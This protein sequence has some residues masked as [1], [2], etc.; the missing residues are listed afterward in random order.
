MGIWSTKS[1]ARLQ[2]EEEGGRQELRRTLT[3]LNLVML[4]VGAIIGAGIFVV[5][6][7]AAAQHAGP[8]I[9]L[10]FVLAGVGCLFAGLCYAEFSAMIPVAGS[11]YTYGYAT[12]GEL[13][14]WLIGWDLMLEYLFA[15]SAVAVGWSGYFT[16]FLRDY[17]HVE[18]PRALTSAPFD[19]EPGGHLLHA[20]GAV[21][22]LP[23]ALLVGVITVMLVLGMRESARLNNVIVVVKITVVLLVIGFGAAH[24]DTANWT[25]FVPENTGT[26]GQF[27][28]SGV[29]SGAGVI[30]FAYIGF[31]A[32]STA[33][34]ETRNPQ[35]DLP[36]GILG[37]LVVCT[38]LYMA[39]ALVMTGLAP[40]ATLNV[41]EPVYV[42][43]AKGG[44]ALAWLKPIVGVGAISGLASVVL[45][46]LMGQPRIF[47][48][49]ARD[50]L[51]P[52]FF[53][54]VH[55]RFH[56]PHVATIITG[57]VAMAVAGLFPIGLLGELVSIGTLFAF[58]VVCAGVLV[59]RYRRPELPRPFRTPFV[60]VVPVLGILTCVGLMVGLGLATWL[61]L[62]VWMALGLA[63][64]FGYGHKH[65]R[66]AQG[67]S[68]GTGGAP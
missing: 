30:F 13:V 56:T 7:T 28:W 64:Y 44:P 39:M 20:T 22:N 1:I 25:P 65:S 31:D 52:P 61:R 12:L 18:L 46:M 17:L 47:Y 29:L 14:A 38:V 3:G 37:S 57:A 23:A 2:Q 51:L 68:A 21:L 16:S 24:V 66:L 10:S 19:V 15:S 50:G 42:A 11:A 9:V 41:A 55:P 63:V 67:E 48:A 60:P 4:G 53:G 26:F 43:I 6:G 49:M 5:T 58:A 34:Q 62:V 32:V 40:H 36:V 35:K 54:H 45:V 59:L 27:G 8:A 33:A